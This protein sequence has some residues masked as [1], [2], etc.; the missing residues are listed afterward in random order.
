MLFFTLLKRPFASRQAFARVDG[1][2]RA[3]LLFRGAAL[4]AILPRGCRSDACLAAVAGQLCRTSTVPSL[5]VSMP[6]IQHDGDLHLEFFVAS[7][8]HAA[9]IDP[10]GKGSFGRCLAPRDN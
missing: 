9:S 6:R 8:L 10:A 1:V 3:A 4:W 2:A 7:V 5:R